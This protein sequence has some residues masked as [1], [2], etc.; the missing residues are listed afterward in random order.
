MI[1][2]KIKSRKEM[3]EICRRLKGE[4]KTIGF[5]SGAFD[6]LHAGHVD[7]LE[8]AKASCDVLVVGVNSDISVKKYKG[9]ERPVVKESHRMRVIAALE[10]VDYVF[11][12][13]ERRNKKNIELLKPDFYIKAGDYKPS[14]LTSKE[15]VEKVNGEVLILPIEETISTSDVIG[16]IKEIGREDEGLFVEKEKAVHIRKRSTKQIPAIFFDRDG[17]VIEDVGYLHDPEK[18]KFLP[19]ALE[20]MKKLYDMGCIHH[21]E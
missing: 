10:S 4:G 3:A 20:G 16:N 1:K 19:G 5:T 14:E 12:F 13:D 6:L 9:E 18:V 11:L 2:N 8:K 21:I 17:T 15:I 7:Y